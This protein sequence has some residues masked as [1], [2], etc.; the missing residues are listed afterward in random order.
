MIALMFL[1][2]AAL[3][4]AVVIVLTVWIPRILGAG[5]P[6]TAAR[7]ILF[8]VLLILPVADEWIGRRQFN[9]I[10]EHEAIVILS[11]NWKNV[12]RAEGPIEEEAALKNYAIPI[13]EVRQ[14]YLDANNGQKFLEIRWYFRGWGFLGRA[15]GLNSLGHFSS[16]SCSPTNR[17]KILKMINIDR[18]FKQER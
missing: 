12:E 9:K 11:P 6:R 5:W 8:P 18:L 17:N 1:L 4:L 2:G 7:F 15:I 14:I 10:C 3:W 16:M 13:K